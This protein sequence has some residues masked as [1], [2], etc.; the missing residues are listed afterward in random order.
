METQK[1]LT[2][3]PLC[4]NQLLN[5]HY[6]ILLYI[7]GQI[8]RRP[9]HVFLTKMAIGPQAECKSLMDYTFGQETMVC[10][11]NVTYRTYSTDDACWVLSLFMHSI[12]FLN[13][14][15]VVDIKIIIFLYIF[16]IDNKTYHYYWLV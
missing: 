16:T 3:V 4:P 1:H 6:L 14:L 7:I 11:G 9:W 15:M 5:F 12:N 13:L 10:A 2:H 8:I